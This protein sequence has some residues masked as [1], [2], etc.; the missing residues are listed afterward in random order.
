MPSH[1]PDHRLSIDD[2]RQ[3]LSLN[4]ARPILHTKRNGYARNVHEVTAPAHD[5]AAMSDIELVDWCDRSVTNHFG[6]FVQRTS[7]TTATVKV[8]VD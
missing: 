3:L 5:L 2:R 6:G 7:A 8:W 1:D 4:L